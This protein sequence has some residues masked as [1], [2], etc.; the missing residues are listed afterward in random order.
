M[1][2]TEHLEVSAHDMPV[3]Q[4]DLSDRRLPIFETIW[5]EM[6]KIKTGK[7]AFVT[8]ITGIDDSG[9]SKFAEAF[10]K[11]LTEKGSKIQQVH[12]DD[13]HNL[14][15]IRYS[16]DNPAENYYF[17]GFDI[18]TIVERLLIP[19]HQK[20]IFSITLKHLNRD[21]DQYETEKEYIFDPDTIVLFEGVFLFRK[22]L[23]PYID[24]NIFLDIS[25]EESK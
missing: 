10:E 1:I 14:K 12:L 17:K 11:Y 16:G 13:F 24:Y 20:K 7:R 25:P 4:V 3:T 8:G 22:E 19:I 5:Y 18:N 9:K 2:D 23:S 21:T 15:S 6:Q